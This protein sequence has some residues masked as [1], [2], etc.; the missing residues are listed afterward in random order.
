MASSDRWVNVAMCSFRLFVMFPQVKYVLVKCDVFVSASSTAAI[1]GEV[2]TNGLCVRRECQTPWPYGTVHGLLVP[3][4]TGVVFGWPGI[5]TKTTR[6][7][8]EPVYWR[9]WQNVTW[10]QAN[11]AWN[12]RSEFFSPPF[13]G[14]CYKASRGCSARLSSARWAIGDPFRI[15]A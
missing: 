11:R 7:D 3:L 6:V 5:P 13:R 1:S 8:P 14:F 12:L 2:L 4:N 15:P 9:A 10:W